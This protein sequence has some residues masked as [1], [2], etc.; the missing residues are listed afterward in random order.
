MLINLSNHPSRLWSV[1][2]L[3]AAKQLFGKIID[4]PF[5]NIPSSEDENY[6]QKLAGKYAIKIKREFIKGNKNK[7]EKICADH[8]MGEMT[9]CFSLITCLESKKYRFYASTTERTVNI[10]TQGRKIS[11]F[12]F[13]GFRK[14]IGFRKSKIDV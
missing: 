6:I 8:L 11:E 14:Y 2:Q 7:T 1:K 9:F 4:I 10:D 5:P 13:V 12:N 3:K